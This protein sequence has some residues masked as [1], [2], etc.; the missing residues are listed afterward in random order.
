MALRTQVPSG[1]D[2]GRRGRSRVSTLQGPSSV[3][4][5]EPGGCG[6]QLLPQ[7]TGKGL[8]GRAGLRGQA[9]SCGT[10]WSE[11]VQA[12]RSCGDNRG[13]QSHLCA[14]LHRTRR[15]VGAERDHRRAGLLAACEGQ[16]RRSSA[17]P[18]PGHRPAQRR[19]DRRR[20]C[21]L[22]PR[23]GQNTQTYPLQVTPSSPKCLHGTNPLLKPPQE[24][25]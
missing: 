3:C 18:R 5:G 13:K 15:A 12:A 21:P 23:L 9:G 10:G 8:Q 6:H 17:P 19:A 2:D 11:R 4:L 16:T 1:G 7:V 20:L 14:G 24:L 22:T 25:T